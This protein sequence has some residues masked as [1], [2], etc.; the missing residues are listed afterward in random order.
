MTDISSLVRI[1]KDDTKWQ[2]TPEPV[3][4][5]EYFVMILQGIETLFIDTGRALMFDDLT[6]INDDGLPYLE[7]DLKLDEK[8]YVLL[9]AQI[10]FLKR[11]QSDVNNIVS[12]STDALTVTNADKPYA[13]IQESI[14]DLER[15]RRRVYYKMVRYTIK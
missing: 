14:G 10:T 8:K 6:K 1:L 2:K 3:L 9:C 11:V 13:H 5:D 7:Y 15:E 12:Y 4:D